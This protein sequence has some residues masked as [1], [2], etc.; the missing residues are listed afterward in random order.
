MLVISLF[1]RLWVQ[2]TRL[3]VIGRDR[4]DLLRLF[5]PVEGHSVRG[6]ILHQEKLMKVDHGDLTQC[7]ATALRK[8]MRRVTQLYDDALR[9]AGLTVT[10]YALMT[11]ILRRG[12]NAPTVTELADATVM[13]RSGLGHTLRPLERDGYVALVQHKEDGRQR[14][15]VLTKSGRA[16]H[17]KATPLWQNAQQRVVEVVGRDERAELQMKLLAIAHDDRLTYSA[18]SLRLPAPPQAPQAARKAQPRS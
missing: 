16:M 8:A 1:P 7:S 9:P 4:T 12:S 2:I 11:E 5:V 17:R 15:V 3:H 6:Y 10:Q 18:N 13:D 14:G